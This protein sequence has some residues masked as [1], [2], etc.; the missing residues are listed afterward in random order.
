LLKAAAYANLSEN[1]F[2]TRER[3]KVAAVLT[4]RL[5]AIG[6]QANEEEK[7]KNQKRK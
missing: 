7:G 3:G 5:T 6:F 4:L 1:V 2:R